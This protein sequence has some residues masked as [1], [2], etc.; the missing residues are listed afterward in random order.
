MAAAETSRWL[1]CHKTLTAR[2]GEISDRQVLS[3][4]RGSSLVA[5]RRVA[6][7]D[8]I[9]W[10]NRALAAHCDATPNLSRCLHQQCGRRAACTG[11]L[12]MQLG[13]GQ[14]SR[15]QQPAAPAKPSESSAQHLQQARLGSAVRIG[16]TYWQPAGCQIAQAPSLPP[17]VLVPALCTPHHNT[18]LGHRGCWGST[19]PSLPARS[20]PG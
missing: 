2:A 8:E 1:C 3:K 11:Q 4:F 17:L 6:A 16:Q 12:C 19:W 20:L 15:R 9:L 5:W 7:G 18:H 14:P 10:A 13:S